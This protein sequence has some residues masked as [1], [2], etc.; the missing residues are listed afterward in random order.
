MYFEFALFSKE[1]TNYSIDNFGV[2]G[3]MLE[4]DEEHLI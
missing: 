1:N 2:T 4:L 3:C